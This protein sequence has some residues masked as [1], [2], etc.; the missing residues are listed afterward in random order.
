M[1]QKLIINYE[2]RIIRAQKLT[3]VYY[4]ERRTI[5]R[6]KIERMAYSTIELL[7]PVHSYDVYIQVIMDTFEYAPV[8]L[9]H[10]ARWFLIRA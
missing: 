4:L 2:W 9:I 10:M 5:I 7:S 1:P 6:A 8:K 3:P